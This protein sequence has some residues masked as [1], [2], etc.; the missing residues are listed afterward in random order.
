MQM[1]CPSC[2]KKENFKG[3]VGA[4]AVGDS[5]VSLPETTFYYCGFCGTVV[6]CL[7]S[8]LDDIS[9]QL[10]EIVQRLDRIEQ[11]LTQ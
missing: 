6:T 2:G 1:A 7:P 3:T 11:R 9:S 8:S 4:V 5:Y 10:A